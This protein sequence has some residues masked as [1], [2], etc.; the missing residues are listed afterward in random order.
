MNPII[1]LSTVASTIIENC[2]TLMSHTVG[3]PARLEP[4]MLPSAPMP[5]ATSIETTPMPTATA[6]LAPITRLLLGTKVNV[7]SPVRWLHSLVID[8]IA[9]IGKISVIGI[10]MAAAKES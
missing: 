10:P 6:A 4:R 3:T 8:N 5:A 7:A 9:M 1:M 2:M